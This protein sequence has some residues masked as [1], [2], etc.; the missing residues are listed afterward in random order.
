MHKLIAITSRAKYLGLLGILGI[1]LDVA[2]MR[3][4][5]LFWLLA[6]VEVFA[7]PRRMWQ[8]LQQ[9]AGIPHI[10][11]THRFHLPSKETYRS[12]I[13]YGLP[14][15]GEWVVVNGGTD[16]R[17]SHS[18]GIPTQR[19]AYD[20]LI[21][22]DEGKTYQGDATRVESYYCYGKKILAPADGEV[23][24]VSAH[25]RDS[26]TFGDGTVDP[27]T[28]DILGNYIIIDHGESEFS[29]IGHLK[30]GSIAVVGGQEVHRGEVIGRCGNSGNTS[31]PHV[32]L[33]VQDGKSVFAS[34]GLPVAFDG[35]TATRHEGYEQR[36][37]R[38]LPEELLADTSVANDSARCYIHRG[39]RVANAASGTP[40][41]SS[42]G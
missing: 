31:E 12:Q 3:L 22:D 33:H 35:I 9:L 11:L 42:T 38:P 17:S 15:E 27:T 24:A 4:L 1:V 40:P 6:L 39:Q 41:R 18:W 7:S 23:V 25:Q 21:I 37:P 28:K 29:F 5:S 20:F 34:A 13:A 10:Y 2:H 36:D 30:P 26:R 8:S 19:Y 16:R 32:H 14:F